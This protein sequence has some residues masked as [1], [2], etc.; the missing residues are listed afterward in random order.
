MTIHARS[1][2]PYTSHLAAGE[3]EATG[4]LATN[5]LTVA[6]A[7]RRWPGRT[8]AEL[9]ELCELERH[10]VARRTADAQKRG[11]I[12]KGDARRCRVSGRLGMTWWPAWQ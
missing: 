8:S 11:M 9:A 1:S 10:E 6:R 2:D 3:H 4:K 7:V 5:L 12:Y